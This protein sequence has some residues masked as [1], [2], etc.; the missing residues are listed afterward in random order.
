MQTV[1]QILKQVREETFYTLEEVEKAT[2]IRKELLEALE[3]DDYS[4]LPPATFVQGFIKNYAKFLKV[5][6]QKLLAVFRREFS[7]RKPYVMD[8]FSNPLDE[9]LKITPG[10]VVGVVVSLIIISFFVYLWVQYRHFVGAPSLVVKSPPDQ[11]ISG[12]SSVVVEGKTDPEIQVMINNQKVMIEANGEFKEK[13]K[14]P[15]QV[16]IITIV[17]IS[18]FGQKTEVFRTVYLKDGII[19]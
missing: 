8:A 3:A 14:L 13:I 17:A 16:S 1:G 11:L 19:P 12:T 9:R 10:K 4:K 15:S 5:D 2:K 6:S 18:K 7:D